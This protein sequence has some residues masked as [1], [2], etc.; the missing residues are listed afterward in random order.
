[1]IG[2]YAGK[3]ADF[4]RRARDTGL[5]LVSFAFGSDSGFTERGEIEADLEAVQRWIDFAAAFPARWSR[6]ARRRWCRRV[7]A[8]TSSR[9]PPKSTTGPASSAARRAS[10]VAVHPS[11]HHNTLLFDRADYDRI[12]ALLEPAGRL[13]A[14]HRPYPA[15][16]QGHRRHAHHLSRPH[17]LPAPQGRRRAGG[18]WAMLARAS[19]TRRR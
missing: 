8:T 3:P 16:P 9:S 2:A 13:G 4:A 12:F 11:S 18:T 1:M 17:P 10:Q 14:G 7:R 5:A 6:W 19:A 15:R